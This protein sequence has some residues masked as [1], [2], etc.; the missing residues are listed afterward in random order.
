[1]KILNLVVLL[2][3]LAGA[4]NWGLWG[5]F[6]FD[7]VAWVFQS[8]SNALSRIFYSIIGLSA[9]WGLS[10]IKNWKT[11]TSCCSSEK[12]PSCKSGSKKRKGK[13]AA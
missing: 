13:R 5:L 6:Q 1:M 2:L 8:D 11:L 4:L 12:T 3:I 10:Y 7:F 9:L